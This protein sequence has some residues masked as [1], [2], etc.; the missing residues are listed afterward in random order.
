MTQPFSR[1]A[2]A[3]LLAAATLTASATP[4]A[5]MGG[6]LAKLFGPPP[7]T[8]QQMRE[9]TP[10]C[11]VEPGPWLGRVSGNSQSTYYDVQ[12]PVSLVGCFPTLKACTL[13]R[14][15]MS[16]SMQGRIIYDQCEPR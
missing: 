16:G 3:G 12:R 11:S 15:R 13:W 8:I 2:M 9:L 6:F 5:A 7:L 4:S 10:S 1:L 14:M